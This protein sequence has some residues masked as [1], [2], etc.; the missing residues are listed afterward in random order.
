MKKKNS[1]QKSVSAIAHFIVILLVI[2]LI[3][4]AT[5]NVSAEGDSTENGAGSP[6]FEEP[7]SFVDPDAAQLQRASLSS[8]GA[9]SPGENSGKDWPGPDDPFTPIP[10]GQD[11]DGLEYEKYPKLSYQIIIGKTVQNSDALDKDFSF[12]IRLK[13]K[14]LAE[15]DDPENYNMDPFCGEK[16]YTKT[17][18]G[19]NTSELGNLDFDGEG[20]AS[21]VL[22]RDQTIH[23]SAIQDGSEFVVIEDEDDPDCSVSVQVAGNASVEDSMASG[24][25]EGRNVL[26]TFTNTYPYHGSGQGQER[27]K[28]SLKIEKITEGPFELG[29]I[30]FFSVVPTPSGSLEQAGQAE[31]SILRQAASSD[32]G[33]EQMTLTSSTNTDDERLLAT[34]GHINTGGIATSKEIPVELEAN[35][36]AT[37]ENLS[38]GW[39][40]VKELDAEDCDV[41]TYSEGSGLVAMSTKGVKWF[42]GSSRI[43]QVV[44]D[45]TTTVTFKNVKVAPGF[46]T[47]KKTV[48]GEGADPEGKFKFILN[49]TLEDSSTSIIDRIKDEDMVPEEGSLGLSRGDLPP[50]GT[51]GDRINAAL[52]DQGSLDLT[53]IGGDQPGQ[54]LRK[55]LT[56]KKEFSLGDGEQWTFDDIPL[57][58]SFT[59]IEEDSSNLVGIKVDGQEVKA[60]TGTVRSGEIVIEFEN[61]RI[62]AADTSQHAGELVAGDEDTIIPATG[63][64][65]TTLLVGFGMMVM[66]LVALLCGG[67]ALK[68][69]EE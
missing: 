27:D 36:S 15:G 67:R 34:G 37:I 45:Q 28:G 23:I 53:R 56:G 58:A 25:V 7:D 54:G 20:E 31:Q 1:R 14:V 3:P 29:R 63:A 21:F 65:V 30:F 13:E 52:S 38:E 24:T 50:S 12:K 39:Y 41:F 43:V 17:T 62:A 46:V 18:K 35:N 49:W 44:K 19:Q 69:R 68:R 8:D 42:P 16:R 2:S 48:T 64:S 55:T 66:A 6:E 9:G 47:V 26:I 60:A 11:F 4:L 5:L 10:P 32:P 33:N 57:G 61:K 59:V 40:L 51:Q 22:K